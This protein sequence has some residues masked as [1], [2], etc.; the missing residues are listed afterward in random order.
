MPDAERRVIA[1][2][3]VL[4]GDGRTAP[5][6]R[7]AGK[8]DPRT[9]YLKNSYVSLRSAGLSNPDADRVLVHDGEVGEEFQHLF[10]AA[11]IQLVIVPYRRFRVPDHLPWRAGYYKLDALA[12]LAERWDSVLLIDTDT[13]VPGTLEDLWQ[14]AVDRVLLL[15][16]GHRWG[17]PARQDI[18]ALGVFLGATSQS[19]P[20]HYGGEFVAGDGPTIRR[21]LEVCQTWFD[22]L[23]GNWSYFEQHKDQGDESILSLAAESRPELVRSAASYVA[24]YW[25]NDGFWLVSTNWKFNSV[26]V[27]H[28]PLEKSQGFLRIFE[29]LAGGEE[30]P[31]L[32]TLANWLSLE[33]SLGKVLLLK[34]KEIWR[35]V[36]GFFLG[37]RIE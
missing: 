26:S 16:T 18:A 24:R 28:L 3:L 11:G 10:E 14:E 17:H 4:Y 1:N 33:R 9:V 25:T 35:L 20:L 13:I 19:R 36:K 37:R 27:W 8:E 6:L 15:D 5:N 29:T 30:L 32:Q 7:S 34:A 22:K 21:F 2:A 12:W 31:P 23:E